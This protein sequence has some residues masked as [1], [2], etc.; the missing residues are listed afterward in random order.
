[1]MPLPAE[2][3]E[4]VEGER[5]PALGRDQV[6]RLDHVV[7]RALADEVVEVE[8]EPPGLQSLVARRDLRGHLPS[9]VLVDSRESLRIRAGAEASAPGLNA[10]QVIEQ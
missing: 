4:A 2:G 5:L 10:E 9:A 6:H 1:M 7:E 8:A 3:I